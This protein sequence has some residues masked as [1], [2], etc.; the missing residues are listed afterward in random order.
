M[1]RKNLALKNDSQDAP[2]LQTLKIEKAAENVSNDSRTDATR[3]NFGVG[4]EQEFVFHRFEKPFEYDRR[5]HQRSRSKIGRSRIF[6]L[7][8]IVQRARSFDRI[9]NH[10]RRTRGFESLLKPHGSINKC[11]EREIRKNFYAGTRTGKRT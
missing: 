2:K 9:S 7:R 6:N 5:Q 4:G 8:K 10:K 11:D 3:H 1:A